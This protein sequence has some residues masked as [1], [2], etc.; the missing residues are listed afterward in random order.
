MS[1]RPSSSASMTSAPRSRSMV[2][3]VLLPLPSPPV[4]PTRNMKLQTSPQARRTNSIGHKH[5]DS[6]RSHPAGHRRVGSSHVK[7]LGMHVTH[8]RRAAFG[9][10][11]SPLAIAGKEFLKL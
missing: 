10:D 3:T 5:R 1:A 6:Q 11:F 7:S 2:A 8:D 4:S 9:E